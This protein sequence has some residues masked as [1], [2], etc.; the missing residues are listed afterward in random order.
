M[1]GLDVT[2]TTEKSNVVESKRTEDLRPAGRGK[3]TIDSG[4]AEYVLLPADM[5]PNEK[6]VDGESRKKG[7]EVCGG[8]RRKDG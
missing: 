4:A 6:L 3:I 8:E 2:M 7:R 5:L 1:G